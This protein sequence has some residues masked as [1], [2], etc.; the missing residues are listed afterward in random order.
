MANELQPEAIPDNTVRAAA[1]SNSLMPGREFFM[2]HEPIGTL[3]DAAID[4]RCEEKGVALNSLP[5]RDAQR[6]VLKETALALR[7]GFNVT[8]GSAQLSLSIRGSITEADFGHILPPERAELNVVMSP[9]AELR[10]AVN[11]VRR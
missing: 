4:A 7:Q 1:H 5:F 11:G 8:S 6:A 10:N 9:G 3:D 2:V